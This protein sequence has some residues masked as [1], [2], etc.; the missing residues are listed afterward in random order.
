LTVA[1][2]I[3]LYAQWLDPDVKTYTV[4]YSANGA[5][6]TPPNKQTVNEGNSVTLPGAGGLANSG[7]T[8]NGWNT[9]A[10]G[11]GTAYAAGAGFTVNADTSFYAQWVSEGLNIPPGATLADK[12]AYIASQADDGIE[13]DIE[14]AQDEYLNPTTVSTMGRNVIVNLS[15]VDS[16]D[17][18]RIHLNTGGTLLSVDNNITLIVRNIIIQGTAFNNNCLIKVGAGG[19]LKIENGSKITGNTN[20]T[21]STSGEGGGIYVNGGILILNGG[22]ITN[23]SC[24]SNGGGVM[25]ANGG[26]VEMYSGKITDN[27]A[28]TAAGGAVFI[29]G[30]NSSFSMYGGEMSGNSAKTWAGGVFCE[31]NSVFKKVTYA[32]N[33]SSGIIYG[34]AAG[35]GI[36]NTASSG[37]AVH[38]RTKYRNRTLGAYDQIS[39]LNLDI[40]WD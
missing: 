32:G 5:S 35:E 28:Q 19:Q 23:N 12:F 1:A 30:N 37:A 15:S 17:V 11:S 20:N 38:C 8:F 9:K 10:D 21:S 27:Q 14:I 3:T 7:K 40:G 2:N 26:T 6:G 39:N 24:K 13:Y 34:S 36:A 16:T 25:V 4:T 33:T 31:T 22:E 18:K 29:T